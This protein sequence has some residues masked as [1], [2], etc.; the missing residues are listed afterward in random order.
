MEEIVAITLVFIILMSLTVAAFAYAL[1][2]IVIRARLAEVTTAIALMERTSQNLVSLLEGD[3]SSSILQF[4]FAYGVV[5]LAE[6]GYESIMADSTTLYSEPH[7]VFSYEVPVSG[8]PS[9]HV[10]DMGATERAYYASLEAAALVYHYSKSG[11]TYVVSDEKVS[12]GEF[13]GTSGAVVHILLL[14][15]QASSPLATKTGAF[16]LTI[17]GVLTT[18]YQYSGLVTLTITSG[19]D[20]QGDS[21][22]NTFTV[23]GQTVTVYLTI[24]TL[25]AAAA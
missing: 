16:G 21:L 23:S 20:Y 9:A 24:F 22:T 11:D 13:E 7:E 4:S 12:V 3:S 1:P 6:D 25:G 8:F 10:L 5:S 14:E 2:T 18:A 17:N 15:L 19:R